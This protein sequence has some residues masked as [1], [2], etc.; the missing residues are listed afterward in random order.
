MG[1][2]ARNA[3]YTVDKVLAF[4]EDGSRSELAYGKLLVNPSPRLRHRDIVMR[5]GC[6]LARLFSA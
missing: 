5:L 2:P 1:M 3:C 4:P 6:E